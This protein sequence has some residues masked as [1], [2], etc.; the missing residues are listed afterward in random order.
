MDCSLP[1]SADHGI[2][3]AWAA[4]SFSRGSGLL[5]CRQTLSHLSHQGSPKHL[6]MA[7]KSPIIWFPLTSWSHPP[8]QLFV[9]HAMDCSPQ[10]TLC[11]WDS[12][13]KNT[14]MGCHVSSRGSSQPRDWTHVSYIGGLVLYYWAPGEALPLQCLW[15]NLG[16]P[17]AKA[18]KTKSTGVTEFGGWVL[19]G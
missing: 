8:L 9:T 18:D 17:I 5:H 1:G 3:L 12:P 6:V 13:G 2:L 14:G 15:P 11:P 7:Y 16:L 4:I 19:P 10:G